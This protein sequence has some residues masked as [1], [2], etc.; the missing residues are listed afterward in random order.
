MTQRTRAAMLALLADN[1]A[2]DI[3]EVDVRD[4]ADSAIFPEDR[5]S[6]Y[7]IWDPFLPDAA[8][9]ADTDEFTANTIANWTGVYTGDASVVSDIATTVRAGMYTFAPSVT[10]R[11]RSRMKAIISGDFTYHTCVACTSLASGDN[12]FAGIVL[13]DGVTAGAGSQTAA[14]VTRN[15]SAILQAGKLTWATYG[16]AATSAAFSQGRAIPDTHNVFIRVRR[17]SGV[18][19]IAFSL[20]GE[21][22]TEEQTITMLSGFTPTHVG[23]WLNSYAGL[24]SVVTFRFF[25][26]YATGTQMKTGGL[27]TIYA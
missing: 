12:A 25:R 13:A 5:P 11:F 8:P 23:L 18:Y 14:V 19:L 9:H 26:V 20:D 10:Y 16:N 6:K 15:N 3:Q 7:Q 17:V 1:T 27:R 2:G 22:Y 4:L 24:A 21:N